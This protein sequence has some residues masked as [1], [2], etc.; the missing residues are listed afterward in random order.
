LKIRKQLIFKILLYVFLTVC[1]LIFLYSSYTL[2]RW[3]IDNIKIQRLATKL[4]NTTD[5][6][7]QP[8]V[9]PIP[10]STNETNTPSEVIKVA[11]DYISFIKVPYINVNFEDLLKL[12]KDV[13]GWI[14][15]N[16]T[17]INYPILQTTNNDYYMK[18]AFNKTN[19]T[20]GWIF[21][22]YRNNSVDFDKNTIIYGHARVDKTMFGSLKNTLTYEWF[23]N[24][25]NHIIRISTPTK[26][27]IWQIFSVYITPKESFYLTTNFYN[28]KEY[29]QKFINIIAKRS[30]FNFNVTPNVDDKILTLS[31]C[32]TG[33]N[34][35]RIVVH[36]KLISEQKR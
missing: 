1:T 35:N 34:K 11:N 32:Q 7:E 13:V 4:I 15:I 33:N 3:Y 24:K 19:N 27:T 14:N 36:A 18:H 20:A 28:T 5:I 17:N 30:K 8:P 6:I 21:M 29:F 25:N 9:E 12:N 22:D 31:T 26:N 23:N 10:V 16:N 2:T